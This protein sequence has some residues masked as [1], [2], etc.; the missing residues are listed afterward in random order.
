MTALATVPL[1]LACGVSG[2][3]AAE[4]AFSFVHKEERIDVP[5]HAFW[6]RTFATQAFAIKGTRRRLVLDRP[7]LE[8]CL[9]E[10]IGAKLRQFTERLIGEPMDIVVGCDVIYSAIIR[11][12]IGSLPC[13]Q[14]T[15]FEKGG[16]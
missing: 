14:V 11:E 12:P 7:G 10:D 15:A 16:C 4:I 6:V 5:A 13:I 2:L 1:S 8:I 9:S 3:D